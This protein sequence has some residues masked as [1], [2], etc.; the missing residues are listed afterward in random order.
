MT[1]EQ[2][3]SMADT[4]K[5]GAHALRGDL[6]TLMGI[7]GLLGA[8]ASEDTEALKKAADSKLRKLAALADTLDDAARELR[9]ADTSAVLR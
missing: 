4:L 6:M 2:R 5:A 9:L 3:L 1:P 7:A 8:P